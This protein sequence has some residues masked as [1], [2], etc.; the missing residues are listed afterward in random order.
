MK[1]LT[2][3]AALLVA[4][5]VGIAALAGAATGAKPDPGVV[6]VQFLAVS[7]WHGQ[8]DPISGVGGAPAIA[9][10]W[11]IDRR[12]NPN[13]LAFTAGDA[14]G[15]SPPISN[16]FEETPAVQALRMMG[17]DADTFGNHNFDRGTAHLQRMIDVARAPSSDQPGS[18]FRYLAAN[19]ANVEDNLDGVQ[20]F[21]WF[22]VAG[23]KIAVIGA[24][25][26]EAPGVVK[27]GSFGT[28]EI[29][30]A[31]AAINR[32]A[33]NARNGGADLVVVLTHKGVRGFDAANNPFGE[34]IDLANAVEGVDVI[35]G[36]HTDV[37]YT[38]T[39]NGVLVVEAR[40]KG[41]SYS[42]TTV[43][44]DGDEG[45]LSKSSVFVTP[46]VAMVTPRADI[47]KMIDEYRTQIAPIM[48]RVIGTAGVAIP[49]SDSCARP[50]GRLCESKVGNVVTDA[51][52][53]ST[54]TD[55]AVTNSGGLR[56][57]LT[58][59]TVDN[60]TDFCAPFT[61]PPFPITR[62]QV[63]AVL[64]FGNIVVT[65]SLNGKELKDYLETGVASMPGA[66]GRFAQVSGLCFTYDLAGTPK[67]ISATGVGTPFTGNRVTSVVRQNADGTC[68]TTPVDLSE[69][70]TYTLAIN[71]FM[72]TGGDGYLRVASRVTSREIM[73]QTVADWIGANS[74]IT[75]SIQGRVV[76]TDSVA[77]NSCPVQSS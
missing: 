38:G 66:N 36:D 27:P 33:R 59:P 17:L 24:V 8:L 62:G 28:I 74:P 31:A 46:T 68:S 42:Q 4:L 40:S 20:P 75:P 22:R 70:A 48:S 76:C 39:H 29:T 19:L 77:P 11:D 32:R 51:M 55:F 61:P 49:R 69:T 7:D 18:P 35:F 5:L 50:D 45:V 56:A 1:R 60:P 25:N 54:G 43:T 73:D 23:L 2:I 44:V 64:P 63:N 16:F 65:L 71:D 9:A 30:D 37:Q 52:R 13:T 26:E 3:V 47:A 41:L 57:D 58:C 34:L 53:L 21:S 15:A 14:Y 12:N 72:G 10:Y 67:T 6:T